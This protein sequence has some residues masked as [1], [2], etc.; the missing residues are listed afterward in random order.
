MRFLK[1]EEKSRTFARIMFENVQICCG[2]YR[3][4]YEGEGASWHI[5]DHD[6]GHFNTKAANHDAELKVC[7]MM[8]Y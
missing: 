4:D 6:T 8:T 7:L 2:Q 5:T 3:K 1:S